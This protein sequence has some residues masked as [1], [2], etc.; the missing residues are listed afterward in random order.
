MNKKWIL[1]LVSLGLVACAP[2]VNYHERMVSNPP[3]TVLILPPENLTSNTEVEEKLYP[4]LTSEFAKRGYYVYSPEMIRAIF[5]SNK[6]NEA[7]SINQVSYGKLKDVFG[8]SAVMR[9]KVFDW[10]SKYI[11]ISSSVNVGLNM[12]LQ[13]CNDGL[14]LWKDSILVSESPGGNNGGLL[15]AMVNAAI[16]AATAPYEP[17]AA[18]ASARLAGEL[19]NGPQFERFGVK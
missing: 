6:L 14:M 16:H 2:K 3:K 18:N 11:V 7:A 8:C 4:I 19:P 5:N 17:V 15:G 1:A 10:S 9:T 12:E 13:D